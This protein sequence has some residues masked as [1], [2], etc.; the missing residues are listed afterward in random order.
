MNSQSDFVARGSAGYWVISRQTN[1][2][3][4]P[5]DVRYCPKADKNQKS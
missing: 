3:L 5:F 4:K 2:G 1:R